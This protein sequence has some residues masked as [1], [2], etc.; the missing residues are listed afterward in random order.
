MFNFHCNFH[1]LWTL[2]PCALKIHL[3]RTPN[4]NVHVP[5]LRGIFNKIE[6]TKLPKN[7]SRLFQNSIWTFT[8][9]VWFSEWGSQ[10][11]SGAITFMFQDLSNLAAQIRGLSLNIH[12]LCNC[13]STCFCRNLCLPRR[14]TDGP[15]NSATPTGP[16]GTCIKFIWK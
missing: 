13:S 10:W 6:I 7:S 2:C 8:L 12:F 9:K 3:G 16:F 14:P 4:Y 11:P 5:A 1:C 15:K